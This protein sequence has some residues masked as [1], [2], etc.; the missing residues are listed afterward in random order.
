MRIRYWLITLLLSLLTS[1]A[2]APPPDNTNNICRI[3]HQYPEWLNIT[4]RTQ[5]HYGV[6]IGV[7][8][9]IIYQESSFV[10]DARPP[11]TMMLGIIPWARPTSAYGYSQA[12]NHTW[13]LYQHSTGYTDSNRYDFSD[14]DDFI[15][16]YAS[17]AKSRAGIPVNN[18]YALYLAYH[19]GITNY[20]NKTYLKKPWLLQV[21]KRVQARAKLYQSQL[22]RCWS[23]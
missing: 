23:F 9:A 4:K 22:K 2:T 1:C 6:P 10:A 21:A 17:R 8:M 12:I 11:R 7:Q 13:Q 16:W 18:A 20:K 14:A 15:G 19:E 3:F 5:K